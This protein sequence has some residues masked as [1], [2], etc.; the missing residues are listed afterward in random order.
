MRKKRLLKAASIKVLGT[1]PVIR[2]IFYRKNGR[3]RSKYSKYI[4]S[5]EKNLVGCPDFFVPPRVLIVSETTI[6]QCFSYRVK[7]KKDIFAINGIETTIVSWTK[8][9]SLMSFVNTHTH[10]ILYRVPH[11]PHIEEA[12]KTARSLGVKVYYDI[13]DLVFDVASYKIYL[14]GQKNITQKEKDGLLKGAES[15]HQMISHADLLIGSTSALSRRMGELFGKQVIQIDNAI[16][17]EE[18]VEVSSE[19]NLGPEGHVRIIYGECPGRC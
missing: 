13:D 9:S 6:P 2:R 10:M 7:Q 17:E 1:V 19:V 4:T 11:D 3:I 8:I 14:D 18:Q 12:V 16:K 5:K 15:Y